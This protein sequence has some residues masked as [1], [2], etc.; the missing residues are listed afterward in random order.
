MPVQSRCSSFA[1]WGLMYHLCPT[2]GW[3]LGS[4][5]SLHPAALLF[6]P[7][8]SVGVFM[9]RVSAPSH[10]AEHSRTQPGLLQLLHLN[11]VVPFGYFTSSFSHLLCRA[12]GSGSAVLPNSVGCSHLL[13]PPLC[14][15]ATTGAVHPSD[16]LCPSPDLLCFEL[17]LNSSFTFHPSV[18]ERPKAQRGGRR[19]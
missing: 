9:M 19:W 8:C 15:V 2:L 4:Q 11:P 3:T 14:I 5:P 1:G 12:A 18:G 10:A 17:T 16:C 13:P 6:P 7:G